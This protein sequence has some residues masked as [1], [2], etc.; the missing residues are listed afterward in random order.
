MNWLTKSQTVTILVFNLLSVAGWG[1]V[2]V[3]GLPLP[4]RKGLLNDLD[5]DPHEL[6][7]LAADPA[8]QD[9]IR[10]MH[11]RMDHWRTRLD[12]PHP[13]QSQNPEPK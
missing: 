1:S 13:L 2:A 7:N 12:D 5:Y 6:N 11:D 9:E 8:Y 4:P 3:G 10:E